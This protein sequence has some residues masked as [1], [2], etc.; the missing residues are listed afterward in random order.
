M[1]RHAL[2][3]PVIF[4]SLL[5][6]GGSSVA[7]GDFGKLCL[8]S[9]ISGTITLNGEPVADAQIKRTVSKAHT[10][11]QKSDEARTDGQGHFSMEP[12]FD[13]SVI[14]KILPMEFVVSQQM[15]LLYQGSEYKIWTG[16]KRSPEEN[17]EARGKPL[18]V[19]CELSQEERNIDVE[20]SYYLTRCSWDVE[21]DAP[22]G[23]YAP[24]EEDDEDDL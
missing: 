5:A 16:I 21:P 9:G 20:G 11:G 19:S 14:G 13:R 10:Q 22:R 7:I 8:F 24:P 15:V 23:G 4:F 17:A 12:L 18:V 2:T 6:I 3:I 1:L